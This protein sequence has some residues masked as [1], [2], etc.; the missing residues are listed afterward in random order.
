MSYGSHLGPTRYEFVLLISL[1]ASDAAMSSGQAYL[2]FL[3]LSKINLRRLS[4][5]TRSNDVRKATDPYF[6]TY[7]WGG[8][9]R[10]DV[11]SQVKSAT[12]TFYGPSALRIHTQAPSSHDNFGWDSELESEPSSHFGHAS[13]GNVGGLQASFK[14]QSKADS[15]WQSSLWAKQCGKKFSTI[16][17][18]TQ[19]EGVAVSPT[20]YF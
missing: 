12:L 19:H 8:L 11:Q 13:V 1:L 18:A 10:I 9:A 20:P 4:L 5:L 2:A 7:Y 6:A 15:F 14:V 16:I 3:G 17:I